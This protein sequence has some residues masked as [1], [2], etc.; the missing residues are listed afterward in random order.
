MSLSSAV[1]SRAW[2]PRCGS[3][4]SATPSLWSRA[5]ARW[6]VGPSALT[7]GH[8]DA[9]ENGQHVF[10][11]SYENIF[12]FLDSIGTRN[13]LEFPDEFGVRYPDGH[14]ETFGIRPATLAAWLLGRVKGLGIPTLLRAAP[15]W[16][17]LVRDVAR[18]DD[19]LDEITVDE[20]FDRLGFPAEVRRIMLNSM[21]IGLLNE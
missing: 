7:S 2:P 15:A 11:G 16:A 19:A 21:V 5:T 10:A 14:V 17:R 18:F 3:P 9:I 20:W 8:G 12:R 1:A 6:V 4:N 13:L